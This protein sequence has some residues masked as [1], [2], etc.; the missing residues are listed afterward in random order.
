MFMHFVPVPP[1]LE[2]LRK[3]AHAWLPFLPDISKRSKEP[4]EQLIDY[5]IR[6]DVEIGFAWDEE[7]KEATALAGLQFK[8]Q[9]NDKVG[10]ILWVTGRGAKEWQ[11][12][13]SEI[14]GYL[15]HLGCT[16]CRPL[17]RPGWSRLL[18]QRGYRVTHYVMERRL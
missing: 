7:K 18:K 11:H 8:Q 16:I 10:E 4:V 12:L 9:G 14:E 13:I 15:K 1:N 6:R 5:I 2:T 17:C 3:T